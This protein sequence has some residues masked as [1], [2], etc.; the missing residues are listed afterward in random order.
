MARRTDRSFMD[1]VRPLVGVAGAR[2]G[3]LCGEDG[4]VADPVPAGWELGRVWLHVD[5]GRLVAADEKACVPG[6]SGRGHDGEGVGR[7]IDVEEER[8]HPRRVVGGRAV[9]YAAVDEDHGARGPAEL[10]SAIGSEG[11]DIAWGDGPRP[12]PVI[13][14]LVEDGPAMG[15]GQRGERTL[16]GAR[17]LQVDAEGEDAAVGVRPRLDVLVPANGV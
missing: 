14:E 7:G 9:H 13:V 6:G 17:V 3:A 11:G 16:L 10:A 4:A 8:A 15:A 12:V 5:V 2:G 1:G